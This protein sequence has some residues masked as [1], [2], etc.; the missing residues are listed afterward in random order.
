MIVVTVLSVLY[1]YC[2]LPVKGVENSIYIPGDLVE[3]NASHT[4]EHIVN[5]C[6]AR[7]LCDGDSS[8]ILTKQQKG[9]FYDVTGELL[10]KIC[11]Q[12]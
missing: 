6:V 11:N 3:K 9:P 2:Y 5:I 10:E 1:H 7:H 8:V 12:I 4:R